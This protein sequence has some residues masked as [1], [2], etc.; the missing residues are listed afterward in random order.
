MVKTLG[1]IHSTKISGNFGLKL[2]GLVR[3]NWKS[4]EK[5]SPPF[6]VYHFSRLDR[7][8][9]NGPFHLNIPTHSQSQYLADLYFPRTTWRK[10]LNHCSFGAI[11]EYPATN[12]HILPTL[13]NEENRNKKNLVICK[14]VA[15]YS[16]IKLQLLWIVKSG[17][18][19]V[20]PTSMCSYNSSVASSQAKCM[21]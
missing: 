11:L 19:A 5:I 1:A 15:R 20:T 8:D 12:L 13:R 17:S 18:I 21:F 16:R 10:T 4:F 2:N 14:L 7:S 9:R 6:A 3:S